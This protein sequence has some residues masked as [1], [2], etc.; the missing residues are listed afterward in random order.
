[1]QVKVY[2]PSPI[3]D[4]NLKGTISRNK[5]SIKIHGITNGKKNGIVKCGNPN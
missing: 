1:M 2:A 5:L 3:V 4:A